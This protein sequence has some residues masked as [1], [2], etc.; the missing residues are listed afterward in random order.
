MHSKDAAFWYRLILRVFLHMG[1]A[2]YSV[3][4]I[5][6]RIQVLLLRFFMWILWTGNIVPNTIDTCRFIS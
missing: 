4:I 1:V 6:A 5:T 3:W 2:P